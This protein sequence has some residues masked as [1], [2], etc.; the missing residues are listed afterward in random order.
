MKSKPV[1]ESPP[2]DR[3]PICHGFGFVHPR[4]DGM[5]DYSRVVN[6][7]CVEADFI[8]AKRQ[9]LLTECQIPRL[10]RNWTLESFLSLDA[11]LKE[12]HIAALQ[13]VEGKIHWLT[14]GGEVDHGKTH[15]AIGI[16][17][18]WLAT[19]RAARYA[20]VPELLDE[21]RAGFALEAVVGYKARFEYF[22]NVALLV[23]DD[24]GAEKQSDFAIE[25]LETI[26]NHRY[27]E[28][29]PLVVTTNKPLGQ[30][31]PRIASRL[32][33]VEGARV[34]IL[35]GPEFHLRKRLEGI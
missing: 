27:N 9:K 33:R 29:L 18:K 22:C 35:K 25:K 24:L 4:I 6:C 23:L 31:S 11:S 16:C 12:A 5:P 13:F 14:L 2:P 8:E 3:C 19:G 34:V 7:A 1:S 21:L 10:C 26:V 30:L 32:Q 15:L 28:E 20:Y 17:L